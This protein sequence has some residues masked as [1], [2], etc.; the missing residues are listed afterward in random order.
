MD[1]YNNI[2]EEIIQYIANNVKSNIRELEGAFNK[3]VAF[4]KLEQKE[5]SLELAQQ[6]LADMISPNQKKVITPEYILS[7][8]SEHYSVPIADLIGN[9]RNSKIVTPRQ[10]SMYLIRELTDTS[11]KSIGKLLG[12]RDHTTIMHGIEKVEDDL[13]SNTATQNTVNTLKKKINPPS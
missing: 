12:N 1:G 9:K 10:I 7:I 11:L 4:A 8:V 13:A 5:I 2:N 3:V 6:A